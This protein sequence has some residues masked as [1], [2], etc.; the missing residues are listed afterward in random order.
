M[1]FITP[2]GCADAL[3]AAIN[4]MP[5][6]GRVY[7][8]R[9]PMKDDKTAKA[10]LWAADL[11][12]MQAWFISPAAANTTVVERNPGFRGIGV[13][14]GGDVQA[15]LQ[16]QIEGYCTL[17]DANDS[18][19]IFRD[20]VWNLSL[21]LNKYGALNIP[22]VTH[23]LPADIEQFSYAFV[24]GWALLHYARIGIGFRGVAAR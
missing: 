17:D 8:R 6:M 24:A 16:W 3:E 15:T 2:G 18:E 14:G 7:K 21:E 10:I 20:A 23:Q 4:A 12:R 19:T 5:N 1:A 9:R 11:S 22:G 13:Q